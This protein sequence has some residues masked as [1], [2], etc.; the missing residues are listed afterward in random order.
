MDTLPVKLH[1][2]SMTKGM[3]VQ[4]S[5]STGISSAPSASDQ[6]GLFGVLEADGDTGDIVSARIRGICKALTGDTSAVGSLVVPMADYMLNL[7]P[8]ISLTGNA[9]DINQL[10]S[11]ARL[12]EAG[13]DGELKLIQ[14]CGQ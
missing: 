4:I 8:V 10:P 7:Q 6:T 12:L 1:A 5:P 9:Q 13:V 3:V 2:D 11:F 14:I